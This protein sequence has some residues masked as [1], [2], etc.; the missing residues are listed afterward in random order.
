MRVAEVPN[1]K[2]KQLGR[3]K[4]SRGCSAQDYIENTSMPDR[5][6]VASISFSFYSTDSL[7]LF[8]YLLFLFS[9]HSFYLAYFFLSCLVLF[10]LRDSLVS[11][12]CEL[13]LSARSSLLL[14]T[15]WI[16]SPLSATFSQLM[17]S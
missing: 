9:V 13:S 17:F 6:L 1:L 16:N 12:F 7:F 15:N 10:S 5:Q 3:D 14:F 8:F 11:S 2:A 4:I